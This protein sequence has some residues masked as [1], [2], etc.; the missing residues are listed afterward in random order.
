VRRRR[1]RSW[2]WRSGAREVPVHPPEQA[3]ARAVLADAHLQSR[4]KP[5]GGSIAASSTR[6]RSS[7]A[8]RASAVA[9]S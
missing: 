4:P 7:I 2:V 8:C 9:P 3:L 6:S 5:R 1:H